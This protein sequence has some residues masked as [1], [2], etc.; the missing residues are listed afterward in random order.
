MRLYVI[1][2]ARTMRELEQEV[3]DYLEKGFSCQGGIATDADYWLYQA[4]VKE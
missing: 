2:R 3:E 1:L 4:M